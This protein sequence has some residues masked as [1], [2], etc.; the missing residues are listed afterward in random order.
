MHSSTAYCPYLRLPF[1]MLKKTLD[2][3]KMEL[4]PLEA[5]I[6]LLA[7]VNY[8]EKTEKVGAESRVCRRGESYHSLQAWSELFHWNK[9]KTRRF[10]I[11]LKNQ[12]L[13]EFEN[14][15]ITSRIRIIDYD[16]YVGHVQPNE[17]TK[18]PDDFEN[19]WEVYHRTTQMAAVDKYA[20]FQCWK[21]LTRAERAKAA[22]NISQYFFNLSKTK[23]CVKALNY[24]KNKKFNDEFYA[25]C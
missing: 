13:L 10:I 5:F 17:Q 3:S 6:Q 15:Q 8:A 24:L 23:Y 11:N 1:Q 18:Y 25:Q 2:Q 7:K 22:T 19:F 4:S 20:A 21:K 16:Y 9:S 14:I 12:G